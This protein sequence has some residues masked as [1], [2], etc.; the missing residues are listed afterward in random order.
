MFSDTLRRKA[1]LSISSDR[2]LIRKITMKMAV[3]NNILT[4]FLRH[5]IV[6]TQ[7]IQNFFVKNENDFSESCF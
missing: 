1:R 4:A 6:F 5:I 7:N 3:R 2:H